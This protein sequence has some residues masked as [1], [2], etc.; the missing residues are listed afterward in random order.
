MNSVKKTLM[1]LKLALNEGTHH[2]IVLL[3]KV[4]ECGASLFS[5]VVLTSC[6]REIH[7]E[8]IGQRMN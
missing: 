5:K 1:P 7:G 2:Y 4:F 3:N 8:T 6:N